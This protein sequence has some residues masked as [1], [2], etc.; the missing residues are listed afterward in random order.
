[1]SDFRIHVDDRRRPVAHV[2]A[3]NFLRA[4]DGSVLLG[5]SA[6]TPGEL[7]SEIDELQAELERLRR[8]VWRAFGQNSRADRRRYASELRKRIQRR[9][10]AQGVGFYVIFD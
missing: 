6:N 8:D 7:L 3:I 5:A 9:L 2:E 1:M 4:S 10:Q